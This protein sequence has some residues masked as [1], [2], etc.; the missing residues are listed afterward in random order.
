[1]S[2]LL[3]HTSS[4]IPL[5]FVV[6]NEL[7]DWLTQQ[8]SFVQQWLANTDF[9]KSGLALIP[10]AETGEL[11]QVFCIMQRADDFWA[12][13]ELASKLPKGCY[14][15]QGDESL[16]SQLALGF[17]LGGYEFSEYK[18][19]ATA[20]AQLGIADKTL[21]EQV[22][23]QADA[24]NLARDLVNTPAADMMPQH[25]SQVM[26][27]LADTFDG[28]FTQW[29]GDELLEQNYPT[30]HMVGRASENKPRLLD[31]KW[32]A[33]DA[34]LITL[35]G[36]GVCFDSGGLDLKPSSGM[37]N[38][39]KDMGGA[40]HVI[41]LAQLIMAANLPIRLRVLVP[42][43]ENAV[44]RNAFRPGDVIK[45]RKGIMVEID[46]TDAEGRLVLCDA[47]SEAQND[48]PELIIDF[49]TLT[50]ACRVALGTELPG[51]FSTER[52]V[53]NAIMDSGMQVN[54]PVWQLPLFEQYTPFLK[55]DVA[56]MTN[57]SS[58]PYGGAITAALYLKEF[59][60]PNTPWVHFD[61][62]A[63]NLRALPGRPAGGEALG[64]RAVF[65]YLQ[66]R[67]N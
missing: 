49:A 5:S 50:G 16:V 41:A 65:T 55:S 31:L 4:G 15:I 35:V 19:K 33:I 23:Q 36:K 34:P 14:Q 47:L 11:S 29:V 60:E 54:D 62:M 39:K 20:K 56:D 12:A 26:S 7:T 52:D 30:I 59:V 63:W 3:C 1:M 9:E 6:K 57:C 61:V 44:S 2:A 32:G 22:K 42:A 43:V 24:I 46:N 45:T 28:E 66:N 67:F 48:D 51:F 38:M 27:D 58:T 17:V 10:N 40:A 13:G 64:I 18:Q 21:Y 37:R 53:A 8:P 25:L